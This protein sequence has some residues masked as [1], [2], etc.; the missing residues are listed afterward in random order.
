MAA[1]DLL[2]LFALHP[3]RL[4]L[5]KGDLPLGFLQHSHSLAKLL[6]FEGPSS[7][8]TLAIAARHAS[9]Q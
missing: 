7:L 3:V 4:R 1:N 9:S 8:A 5:S 6:S 2:A